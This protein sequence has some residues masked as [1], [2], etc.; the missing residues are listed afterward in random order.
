SERLHDIIRED[1]EVNSTTF[2]AQLYQIY[3]FLNAPRRCAI[4]PAFHRTQ[5]GERVVPEVLGVAVIKGGFLV[6]FLSPEETKYLLLADNKMKTTILP[7][8]VMGRPT[9]DA[10]LEV[11]ENHSKKSFKYE[12]GQLTLIIKTGTIFSLAENQAQLDIM[13]KNNVKM[14]EDATK[15]E[16]KYNIE[17]LMNT[18]QKDLKTDVMGF[19]DHIYKTKPRLWDEIKDYWDELYENAKVEVEVKV[20][21]VNSAFTK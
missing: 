2:R 15:E 4:L 16:I 10:T 18:L 19:S 20:K 11:L 8:S 21:I 12:N 1:G 3:N 6:G 14:I 7:I 9:A 17:S 5:D 13:D